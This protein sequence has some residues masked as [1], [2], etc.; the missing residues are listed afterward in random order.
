MVLIATL[1]AYLVIVGS[2]I[3]FPSV[4]AKYVFSRKW[5][6]FGTDPGKFN[7]PQG[8]AV[9]ASGVL[10]VADTGNNRI[11]VFK[12]ANPYPVSTTQIVPGVCFVRTWG[13]VGSANGQFNIPS[14]VAL[15]SSGRVYVTDSGNHRTIV[16]K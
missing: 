9:S 16:S 13:T 2:N 14:D 6:T 1:I 12:L 5:G 7:E 8:L 15:D 3:S 11:Q 4:E 10:Y